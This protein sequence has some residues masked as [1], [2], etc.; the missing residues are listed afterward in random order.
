[1]QRPV[2][3]SKIHMATVTAAKPDYVG[4]ITIDA[5]LLRATGM[6]VN[7]RVLVANCRNGARFETY[8]FLGEPASGAIELNGAAAHL[9][10]PGDRVIVMHFAMMDDDEYRAHHPRVAIIGEDNRI[11]DTIRYDPSELPPP[12]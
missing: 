8:I 7:D 5:D 4:S 1:M 12:A 3:H 2:L 9:V 10:E 6:R 11:V